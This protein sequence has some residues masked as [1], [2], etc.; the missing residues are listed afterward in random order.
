MRIA[1][2]SLLLQSMSTHALVVQPRTR[3]PQAM[4]SRGTCSSD[5]VDPITK[6]PGDPSLILTTNVVLQDKAAF[7]KSASAA[8]AEALSKP[9]SYVAICVT[10]NNLNGMSFGGS[11][12]PT[13]LG[14]VYSIGQINQ[15]NNA[16]LTAAISELLERHGGI[17]NDRIYLNFFDVPRAVRAEP[18]GS[19]AA[20]SLARAMTASGLLSHV[21][22]RWC[23]HESRLLRRT[24]DGRAGRLLAESELTSCKQVAPNGS[25]R[26]E[27]SRPAFHHN[28]SHGHSLHLSEYS[29]KRISMAISYYISAVGAGG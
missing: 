29:Y 28:V 16:A 14:C 3:A 24:A 5:A 26:D 9:E 18:F 6:L 25:R 4:A 12:D 27:L 10:D 20:S 1:V 17:S 13:A 11:T 19:L 22:L 23:V 2:T 21:V 15:E 7:V 8:V